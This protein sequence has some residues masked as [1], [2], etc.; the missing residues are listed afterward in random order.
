MQSFGALLL[1]GLLAGLLAGLVAG[2]FAFV[3][4]EPRIDAAIALEEQAAHDGAPAGADDHAEELVSRDGQKAGLILATALFGVAMGGIV[5]TAYTLLR[6]RL[7][8]RRDAHA[9]LV[10]AGS[11]FGG[12]VLV[13]FLKYP[14]SPPGV[15]DPG[16]IDQRTAAFLTM[17]VLGLL[18]VWAGAAAFRAL[19]G[20]DWLR[21]T[22][23]TASFVIT[24]AAG[25]VVLPSYAEVPNGFPAG[26]LWDFRIASLGTQA[27]LWTAIGLIFA[28]LV[29]RAGDAPAADH[30]V[31]EEPAAP[32]G[33]PVET[34]G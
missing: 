21:C 18:A 8:L 9:A 7:R 24:V 14:P 29:H 19:R 30:A 12:A 33:R 11:G 10:V 25:Y 17:V 23:A 13:P 1:R 6:R 22:G 20:P 3:A 2:G 26:L 5:A 32:A 16:T 28:A 4:G 34:A 27:V 15:G 31:G